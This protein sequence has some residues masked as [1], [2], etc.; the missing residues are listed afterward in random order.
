MDN[1]EPC[2]TCPRNDTARNRVGQPQM[3][4][5]ALKENRDQISVHFR[6][7]KQWDE[8][9]LELRKC[10]SSNCQDLQE[11]NSVRI[12]WDQNAQ[13]VSNAGP[14]IRHHHVQYLR[15]RKALVQPSVLL[16]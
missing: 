10:S 11:L 5:C 1:K 7:S 4:L 6:V 3:K 2:T 13:P 15:K 16:L 12:T 14:Q 8:V 9:A